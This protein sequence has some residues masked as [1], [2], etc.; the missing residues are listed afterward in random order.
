[1]KK[2]LKAVCLLLSVVIFAGVFASCGKGRNVVAI[3]DETK[4]IYHS[5]VDDIINYHLAFY[6]QT[7]MSE[8]EKLKIKANAVNAF[9]QYRLIE[10]ELKKDGF[11]IDKKAL[12]ERYQAEKAKIEEEFEGGYKNWRKTYNVSRSF[13]KEETRRMILKEKCYENI[14]A[15]LEITDDVLK[16][17]MNKHAADYMHPSGYG[18]T[19]IF[20]EVKDLSNENEC[21][22]AKT[23]AQEYINKLRAGEMTMEQVEAELL[24]KYTKEDG[25]G[26][27]VFF[28]GSDFTAVQ[29]M[30]VLDTREKLDYWL[31]KYS[32]DY[33]N[34]DA[35]ADPSSKEYEAYMQYISKCMEVETYY[36]IQNLEVNEVYESPVFSLIGYGILCLD[37]IKGESTFDS[38][39]DVK[40][41]LRER[42]IEDTT[43]ESFKTYVNDLFEQYSVMNAYTTAVSK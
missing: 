41:E 29:S 16:Q 7:G 21:A 31:E 8:A 14:Q 39:E 13:L 15:K 4:V 26:N 11:E 36:A 3:Y 6:W 35:N 25:Y 9:V 37:S 42:Y 5:E 2:F 1:M 32:E 19:M 27:A 22:E 28:N 40:E 23:E 30:P 38:F 10:E 20:R 12:N 33:K 17:Y 18:W 43:A 24:A 34:R